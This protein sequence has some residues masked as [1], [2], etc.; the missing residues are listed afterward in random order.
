MADTELGYELMLRC[1]ALIADRLQATRLR[2]LDL[3]T[4]HGSV[5]S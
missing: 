4:P 3:Y 2:L 1:A 5:P